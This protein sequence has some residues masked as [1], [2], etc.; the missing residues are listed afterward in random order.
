MQSVLIYFKFVYLRLLI[1]MYLSDPDQFSIER[2]FCTEPWQFCYNVLYTRVR[3]ILIFASV[4]IDQWRVTI[5][6]SRLS[7]RKL[8]NNS[9]GSGVYTSPGKNR[10]V[11]AQ[12]KILT[13][14]CTSDK[15][16]S[17]QGFVPSKIVRTL[18]TGS[19]SSLNVLIGCFIISLSS[20]R[21]PAASGSFGYTWAPSRNFFSCE[22]RNPSKFALCNTE[23]WA[24]ESGIPLKIGIQSSKVHW[25]RLESSIWN[26]E[27]TA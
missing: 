4:S 24:L 5:I 3:T 23:S 25:Q 11:P 1:Y 2:I 16:K 9:H 22:I 18:Q 12:S 17:M 6:V 13:Y 14:I 20:V 27:S 15:V 8:S 26:P 21:W 10:T 19:K 7:P